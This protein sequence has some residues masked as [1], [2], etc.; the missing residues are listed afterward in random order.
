LA[1][2]EGVQARAAGEGF[3]VV[4]QGLGEGV[5]GA[6]SAHRPSASPSMIPAASTSNSCLAATTVCSSVAAQVPLGI[7]VVLIACSA[8]ST[9]AAACSGT[10]LAIAQDLRRKA[11]GSVYG[12]C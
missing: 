9:T 3:L 11:A 2:G 12:I 8:R 1:A 5:R 7:Q 4:L 10:V 6:A